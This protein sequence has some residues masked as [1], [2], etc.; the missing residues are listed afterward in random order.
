MNTWVDKTIV[1][2]SPKRSGGTLLNNLFDSHP[3]IVSFADEAFFWEHVYNYQE[4]G[5]ESLFVDL[6][7][8]FDPESL[9]AA[10]ID[11][12]ILPWLDGIFRGMQ[13]N[14]KFEIDLGFNRKAFLQGLQG[15]R[16]CSSISDIWDCLVKAYADASSI[17]YSRCR[18]GFMFGGDW[19]RSM[20]A[21]KDTLKN[22]RCIFIMRNPYFAL[23]SLKKSRLNWQRK[24]LHPI[25]F[26]EVINFYYFF[27]N[28]RLE[29]LDERTI[30]IRFED[31]VADPVKTMKIVAKHVGVEYTDNLITPTLL[32][33]PYR[34]ESSFVSK[35]GIDVSAI[36]RKLEILN[37]T[38]I[39]IIGEHLKPILKYFDY[40]T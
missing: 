11:R 19:G 8:S 7:R 1:V 36:C 6:F 34:G 37:E 15:F 32:G 4:N 28:N 17:D 18:T 2:S 16:S 31:L 25:N 29:I 24:F 35:E 22:C 39:G 5:M 10:M 9:E 38:E 30:L 13:N 12:D 27:W 33:K 26:A 3:G 23:E 14:K 20:L 21:T 40:K